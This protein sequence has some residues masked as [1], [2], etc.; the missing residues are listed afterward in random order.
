MPWSR[1]TSACK[2]CQ[3]QQLQH[4]A[5][6]LCRTCYTRNRTRQTGRWPS[7]LSGCLMCGRSNENANYRSIGLCKRCHTMA[8][9]AGVL[10]F[11]RTEVEIRKK[12]NTPQAMVVL[13]R[14]AQT[15]GSERAAV[16]LEMSKDLFTAYATGQK[17][18]PKPLLGEAID[19][20]M[21]L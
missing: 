6:G 5:N 18:P 4:H 1:E 15:V 20:W 13:Q 10:V 19:V 9:K 14:I 3:T 7:Y 21:R 17:K 16:L 2:Q 11:W 8:N 12:Q